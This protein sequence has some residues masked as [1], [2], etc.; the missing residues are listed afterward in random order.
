MDKKRSNIVAVVVTF[1]RKELL[2]ECLTALL[3]QNRFC[4]V[5]IVDNGST[6][7]TKQ[8]ICEYLNYSNVIYMNT[9]A[10]LGGAGGF[11]FGI[12]RAYELGYDYFW[13]MDDD[14]IPS[15]TALDELMKAKENLNGEFGYLSSLA[16]WT[17]GSIC[18]M[19]EVELSDVCSSNEMC[20][21]SGIQAINRA[22]FVSFLVPKEI[23][24]KIGLPIKE[25]FIW[26]DDTNYCLRINHIAQGYLVLN[27]KVVHKMNTNS[28]ADIVTDDSNRL[29][30][31]VYAFRNRFFN[32]RMEKRL[33]QLYIY[34]GK[35]ICKVL[36]CS[37]DHKKDRIKYM[38]EGVR[39]GITFKPQIE[40]VETESR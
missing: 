40:Y 35:K 8:Y 29:E 19:N 39:Q 18:R 2:A 36:F 10:N 9:A 34:L 38:L 23:V 26:A 1:N 32:Y 31:Y 22:T 4:D 17:D 21:G 37:K 13:L 33:L 7:G 3:N 24:E 6:D 25:F 11:N 14:T 20:T 15:P 12:R 30:R 27:S 28:K 5:L 16:L